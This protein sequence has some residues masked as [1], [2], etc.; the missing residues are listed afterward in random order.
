[1]LERWQNVRAVIN[2]TP[3]GMSP[4]TEECPYPEEMPLPPQAVV[5]DLV[6]NPAETVLLRRA[7]RQGLKA[8]NGLGMLVEQARLAFARWTGYTPSAQ[9]LWQALRQPPAQPSGENP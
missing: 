9:N 5:Y 7:R 3:V 1:V 4:H 8:A 6:Y 2:A